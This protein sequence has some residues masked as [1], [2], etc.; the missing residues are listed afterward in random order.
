MSTPKYCPKC[1]ADF[2]G[3]PIPEKSR[4]HYG[5]ETHFSRL[6]G[7]TDIWLDRTVSWLCPDCGHKWKR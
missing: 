1:K 7:I 2:K 6:I 3:A 4:E 5:N